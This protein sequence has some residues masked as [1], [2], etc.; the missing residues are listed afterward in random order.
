M[1]LSATCCSD[2]SE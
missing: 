2:S 1:K